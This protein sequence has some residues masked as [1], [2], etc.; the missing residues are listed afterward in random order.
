MHL[1]CVH[2]FTKSSVSEFAPIAVCAVPGLQF[3]PF[4]T[5]AHPMGY[6][7]ERIILNGAAFVGG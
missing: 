1:Y 5:A 3:L 4:F 7:I 2:T 6:P